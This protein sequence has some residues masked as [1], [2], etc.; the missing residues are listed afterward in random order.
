MG[1]GTAF[2]ITA[3]LLFGGLYYLSTTLSP[4]SGEA[5]Y[6]F[7]I[8][9]S[10]PFVISAIFLFKQ[11]AQFKQF[12]LQL[13]AQPKLVAILC[14]T[15]AITGSQMWL[16]V[17]APNNNAAIDVSI[18]YLLMP[19]TMVAVGYFVFKERLSMF[20]ILALIFAIMGISMTILAQGSLSWTTLM[21][22]I[23]YPVYFSLRKYFG[24]SHLSSFVC[25]IILMLPIATYFAFQADISSI[26]QQNPNFPIALTILGVVS[27]LALISYIMASS[28]ISINLL[29]LLS[30]IE[31][32]AMLLVSFIIGE[33]LNEDAYL[34]MFCL[35]IAILFLIID[36][37]VVLKK[38]K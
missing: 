34:L 12:L 8:W 30:Y 5:I 25:E 4:L 32:F 33:T 19:I 26:I 29:G 23:G 37:I 7:R 38:Q 2:S 11:T 14:L 16:F 9:V 17:W 6:G 10:L 15:A 22:L 24:I 27:G 13:L 31:P 36:G 20:K 28:L 18:G 35:S 3:S 21:V 1:K